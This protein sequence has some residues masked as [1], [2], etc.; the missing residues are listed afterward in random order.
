MIANVL[1]FFASTFA[2][3]IA[4]IVYG[5]DVKETGDPYIAQMEAALASGEALTPGRYLVE[6]L[7]ILRFVPGWMP[8]ASFQKTFAALPCSATG[9]F[10][11]IGSKWVQ[12]RGRRTGRYAF[13]CL[14]TI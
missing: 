1:S 8:G 10:A 11:S 9:T 5:F 3:A 4:K 12:A 2:G 13:L 14:M 6:Y 7:P